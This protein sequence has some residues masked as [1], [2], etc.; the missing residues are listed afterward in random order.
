MV[1]PVFPTQ[2]GGP[3]LERVR[4]VREPVERAGCGT[5]VEVGGVAGVQTAPEGRARLAG[6]E[7]EVDALEEGLIAGG[8]VTIEATGGV[9][10]MTTCSSPPRRCCRPGRLRGRRRCAARHRARSR[11]A[12][13]AQGWK[14]P[15]RSS[16]VGT[17]SSSPAPS[18]RS[19][20]GRC[21]RRRRPGAAAWRNRRDRIGDVDRPRPRD[22]GADILRLVHGADV[23]AVRAV[24]EHRVAGRRG[25]RIE[26]GRGVRVEA[27]LEARFRVGAREV[28]GR[29]RL[30]GGGGRPGGDL[31]G[32]RLRVDRP[33]V[34]VRRDVRG[35]VSRPDGEV[36]L[37]VPERAE[38][39]A[40]GAWLEVAAVNRA[41]DVR[42]GVVHREVEDRGR[43]LC[44]RIGPGVD[45]ADEAHRV[46]RPL[47]SVA[48]GRVADPSVTVTVKE[49]SPWS[50][51]AY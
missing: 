31:R 28:E 5:A 20:T 42:G 43:V 7:G 22:V 30:A 6:G 3:H 46:D 36:V 10:S 33:G 34:G 35:Q 27:A 29:R 14:S 39:V 47:V 48:R 41:V 38:I 25:A 21:C 37:A 32:R 24:A 12:A 19:R 9:V 1:G 44:E 50:S 13:T 15:G 4:A 51:P 8:P 18:R 17:R 49:C 2:V 40:R 16:R 23:E 26:L 45:G 11:A